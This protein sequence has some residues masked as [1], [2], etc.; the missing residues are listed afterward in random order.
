MI[1]NP[2]TIIFSVIMAI[3]TVIF[4]DF[5]KRKQSRLQ[6]DW[7]TNDFEKNVELIRPEFE[8]KVKKKRKNP[9]TGV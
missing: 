9:I 1:D 4:L 2:T 3:W 5:W 6:F 8:N 7:D